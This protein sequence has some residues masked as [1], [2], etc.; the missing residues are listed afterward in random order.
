[1]NIYLDDERQTP[2]GYVR[3]YSVDETIEL[4]KANNG[5]I[6]RLSLDNDLGVGYEEGRKVLNWIEEQSF[7]NTLLPIPHIIIHTGNPVAA[8]IMMKS[9]YNS[10]K[11]WIN[12]GYNRIEWLQ[13]DYI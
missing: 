11:H 9:R 1:M 6:E 5:N 4:I 10:W 2:N 13:K 12:H 7:N 8:D 3:T